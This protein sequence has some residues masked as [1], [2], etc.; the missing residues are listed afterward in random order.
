MQI[1]KRTVTRLGGTSS[2]R[3]REEIEGDGWT[4]VNEG[5]LGAG[6]S[7][8]EYSIE[9][10]NLTE[11]MREEIEMEIVPTLTFGVGLL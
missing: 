3:Y 8:H 11:E 10:E 5:I 2:G 9:G 1:N 4:L 6:R 7:H